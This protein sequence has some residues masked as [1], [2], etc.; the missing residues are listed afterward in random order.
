MKKFLLISCF[1]CSL[2]GYGQQE[3]TL[4]FM[5]GIGQAAY[6]NPAFTPTHKVV[7]GLPGIS[8]NYFQFANTGFNYN[9]LI[10]TELD[11]T[12]I[13]TVNNF[14]NGLEDENYMQAN[15]NLD[16]FHL[17]FKANSRLFL[18]LSM[19]VRTFKRLMYPKDLFSFVVE[20]NGSSLSQTLNLSPQMESSS[21]A[22]IGV[23]GSYSV[24]EK[25]NL[26][27]RLKIIGGIEN[28]TTEY[29]DFEITTYEDNYD[30]HLQAGTSILTSNIQRWDE[31]E[32]DMANMGEYMSNRGVALDFGATYQFSDRFSMGLSLLDL[33]YVKWSQNTHEYFMDPENASYTFSGGDVDDLMEDGKGPFDSMID[34]AEE[35]F[36]FENRTIEAYSTAIPSRAYLSGSYSITGSTTFGTVFFTEKYKE[37]WNN[38]L[39]VNLAQKLGNFITASASYS[40][41]NNSYDNVGGGLSINLTPLQIYV[42][43]DNLLTAAYHAAAKGVLNDY[44]NNAKSVNLG[45]G[46][47]FVFGRPKKAPSIDTES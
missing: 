47:N 10:T 45:F 21:Y 40:A 29:S 16:L 12:K 7:I 9:D 14:V 6:T 4:H 5:P 18:S 28:A 39:S 8:S 15:A 25:L 2:L 46:I 3:L 11:G 31:E 17:T 30:I 27:A 20:G 44:I 43:S 26:G 24:N 19:R 1:F 36:Q 41:M 33:G 42:V 22:E 13:L 38:G 35:N 32:F 37:R 23:G 34:A